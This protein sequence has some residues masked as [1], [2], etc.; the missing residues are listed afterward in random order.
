MTVSEIEHGEALCF[1]FFGSPGKQKQES[2][3]FP[4]VTLEKVTKAKPAVAVLRTSRLR[5]RCTRLRASQRAPADYD[6]AMIATTDTI[7][8]STKLSINPKN[9]TSQSLQ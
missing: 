6:L 8:A 4:L 7:P 2:G 9:F 5:Y 1:W 3:R